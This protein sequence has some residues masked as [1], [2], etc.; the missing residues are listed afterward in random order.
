MTLG[1]NIADNG[2][3]K[4]AFETWQAR[5]QSDPSG[6]TIKNPRLPGLEALT[7]EQLFFVSYARLW[8]S[9]AR[10]ESLLQQV[11]TDPHSPAEWRIKGAV[12]NSEYFARAFKCKKGAPMNPVKK[13]DVW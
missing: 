7:P 8:C 11:M 6:K 13:C 4:K 5:Y 10:P 3:L 1:E 9:K 2:G 12:Q